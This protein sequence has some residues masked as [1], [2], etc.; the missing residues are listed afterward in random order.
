M[1]NVID[2]TLNRLKFIFVSDSCGVMFILKILLIDI[3]IVLVVTVLA[4][5]G[6]CDYLKHKLSFL[7]VCDMF[8]FSF[9]CVYFVLVCFVVTSS[10]WQMSVNLL[11]FWISGYRPDYCSCLC[12]F[13]LSSQPNILFSDSCPALSFSHLALCHNDLSGIDVLNTTY[14]LIVLPSK[15]I[16]LA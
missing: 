15:N 14:P 2:Y 13:F 16:C 11:Q 1:Y 12:H 9:S 10:L 7:P 4:V 6:C 8:L 5:F 3:D